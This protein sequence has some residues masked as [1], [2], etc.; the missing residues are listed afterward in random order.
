M[1]TM[2]KTQV[3]SYA[4]MG[5]KELLKPYEYTLDALGP[6]EV[7]VQVTHCGICH[8]DLHLLDNDWGISRYPL[9]PGHEII[10]RVSA[11]GDEVKNG[12]KIGQ[13]VGIGWQC[14]SCGCCSMCEGGDAELC[15]TQQATCVGHFG[16]FASTVH[17]DARFVF[18]IPDAIPSE[19]A[20]PLLCGG[21]TVF[22]PFC[23]F[24]VNATSSVAVVGIGGLGHIALQFARAFGCQVTACSSSSAKE[25]E[26]RRLGAHAFLPSNDVQKLKVAKN[27]FDLILVTVTAPLDW[28]LYV[29]L[30]R[31]K[32]TLCFVGAVPQPISITASALIHGRKKLAGSNIASPS[33]MRKMLELAARASVFPLVEQ[34]D[35]KEVNTAIDK[36]RRNELRY[37]AVLT[38]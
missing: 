21:A 32:G 15:P 25:G 6:H 36:L 38:I 17:A 16:G 27:S 37:R 26:A 33:V 1:P 10:G 9:V 7:E 20:G 24:H 2:T 19:V 14:N 28:S 35:L 5:K 11:L 8:S 31:P 23:D 4:A 12:L 3:T 22:S 13:R 30:L 18:P 29:D 34:F